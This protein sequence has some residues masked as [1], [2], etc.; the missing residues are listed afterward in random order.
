M[1]LTGRTLGY[2]CSL[3][4][5]ATSKTTNHLIENIGYKV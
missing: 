2:I 5:S 4:F 1:N 3:V